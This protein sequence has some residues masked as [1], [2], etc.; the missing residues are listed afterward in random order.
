[1][2]VSM[3]MSGCWFTCNFVKMCMQ[4]KGKCLCDHRQSRFC[5]LYS[6]SWEGVGRWG[7][8]CGVSEEEDQK[9]VTCCLPPFELIPG[10]VRDHV[11]NASVRF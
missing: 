11:R 9:D 1:M 2:Y 8:V 5:I 7:V 6:V 4:S 10:F 3:Y